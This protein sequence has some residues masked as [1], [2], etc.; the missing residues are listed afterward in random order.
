VRGPWL[1]AVAFLLAGCGGNDGQAI[2]RS[3]VSSL[4]LQ[5]S[6][7]PGVF[8]RFDRG[9]LAT[10][11]FVPGPRLD[12]ARFGREDGWKARY[13]RSGSAETRGP[14]VIESRADVFGSSKDAALDL[15]AYREQFRAELS[16]SPRSVRLLRVPRV[17]E[18]TM[19]MTRRQSGSPGVRLYT[20][21]WREENV[22][23]SV[24]ANGFEG[25]L[26]LRQVLALARKQAGH[27]RTAG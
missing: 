8:V 13:K 6:D 15:A 1:L 26:A 7:L 16:A 18:E 4:V 12:P 20:I 24:S 10:T 5:P 22:T 11:D 25:K 14:L 17:G 2:P 3:K 19:A 21:A 9:R 27:I 23:A